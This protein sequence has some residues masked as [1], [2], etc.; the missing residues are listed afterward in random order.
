MLDNDD[1]VIELLVRDH[2]ILLRLAEDLDR[3]EEAARLATLF[4]LFVR[5][6]AA[7]EAGEQQVVFPFYCDAVLHGDIEA[8][9]RTDE[10]EEINELLAEMRRLTP[11][12][13]GFEKRAAALTVELETHFAAEEEDVF[14]QLRASFTAR[15]LVALGDRVRAVKKTA[16]PF[17]EPVLTHHVHA[18][19]RPKW[20]G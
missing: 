1:D 6:L 2:Q 18:E 19:Q 8:R 4:E 5:E 3:E 13:V 10:H 9:R 12:D 20:S 15:D 16:P 17:P 11:D 7:H 14:P